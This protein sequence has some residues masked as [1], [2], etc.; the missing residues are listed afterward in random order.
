MTGT[1]RRRLYR[2]FVKVIESGDFFYSPCDSRH[3]KSVAEDVNSIS[4]RIRWDASLD[5]GRAGNTGIHLN[6]LHSEDFDTVDNR[7]RCRIWFYPSSSVAI[8]KI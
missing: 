3:R 5:I 6:L 1:Y 4:L 7:S 2:I 8:S